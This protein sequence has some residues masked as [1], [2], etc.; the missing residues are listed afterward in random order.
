M[1]AVVEAIFGDISSPCLG[2]GA[3]VESGVLKV[4]REI[5]A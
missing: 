5:E 2:E 3:R 4:H 1:F